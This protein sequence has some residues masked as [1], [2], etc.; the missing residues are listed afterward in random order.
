MF[1]NTPAPPYFAVIFTSERI[2]GDNG[3]AETAAR[4]VELASQQPGF[5]GIESAR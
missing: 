2:A 4:I 5:L 3:Y 1:A